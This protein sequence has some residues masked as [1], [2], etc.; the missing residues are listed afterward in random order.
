MGVAAK[1]RLRGRWQRAG[2]SV[3]SY[4]QRVVSG[5]M[6]ESSRVSQ[7][8]VCRIHGMLFPTTGHGIRSLATAG[9]KR[10]L[11]HHARSVIWR[12]RA[13]T[14][15]LFPDRRKRAGYLAGSIRCCWWH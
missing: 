11:E 6:A 12:V 8:L 1:G 14:F 7:T 4:C 5:S 13:L 2:I 3:T 9:S 15:W 10:D